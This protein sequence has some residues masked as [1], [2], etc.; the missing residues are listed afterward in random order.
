[1]F[2]TLRTVELHLRLHALLRRRR[3][4]AVIQ[5][6]LI[7]AVVAVITAVLLLLGFLDHIQ[8][9]RACEW[10]GAAAAD[11]DPALSC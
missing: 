2:R 5:A 9:T 3:R 10:R 6:L 1:M 11:G 4:A 8:V 7:G